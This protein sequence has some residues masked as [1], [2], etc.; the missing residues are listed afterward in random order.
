MMS[1]PTQTAALLPQIAAIMFTRLVLNTGFRM[2]YPLMPVFARGVDVEISTIVSV[3]TLIQ[4]MGFVSPLIG[5]LSQRRGRKFTILFGLGLYAIG[6]LCVFLI[7]T[8]I[9]LS[10]AL[11]LGALGKTAFDPAVQAYIGERVVYQRRGLYMGIVELTWSGAFLIGVPLMTALIG[12]FNWQAPFVLL[13]LLVAISAAVIVLLLETDRPVVE[14]VPFFKAM[15]VAVNSPMA[16]AG[17]ALGFAV[18]GANQLINVIF[19]TWIENT[20]GIQL[21]ALAIASAVIGISELG[22]EG[23]VTVLADRLGKRRL[24]MIGICGNLLACVLLPFTSFDLNAALF[25]LFWFYLTFEITVVSMIPLNSELSPHARAMY[26]TV[27]V[28]AVTLGRAI[29]TPV[30]WLLFGIGIAANTLLAAGLNL[31]ALALIWKFISVK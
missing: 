27:I 10:L 6:M 12:A 19:G 11:M 30:A 26:L 23:I 24:V 9:G 29:F 13:A 14:R 5:T 2:I 22:G 31:I 1:S 17:L 3:V 8:I 20:F 16:L 4:L 28:T 21:A 15:R 18:T 7:P 25:G